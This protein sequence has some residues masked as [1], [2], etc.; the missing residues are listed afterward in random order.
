[1]DVAILSSVGRE[2]FSLVDVKYAEAD[3]RD[4]GTALMASRLFTSI[5]WSV[6]QP[7]GTHG[8]AISE[9]VAFE[10]ALTPEIY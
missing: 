8:F 1:M 2:I 6:M 10:P 9:P 5:K 4:L 3:I 7:S